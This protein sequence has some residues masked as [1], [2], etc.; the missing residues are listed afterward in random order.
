[1]AKFVP[2]DLDRELGAEFDGREW[3]SAGPAADLLH[4]LDQ[5]LPEPYRGY[6]A[7]GVAGLLWV[8]LAEPRGLRRCRGHYT[9]L[10]VWRWLLRMQARNHFREAPRTARWT[11]VFHDTLRNLHPDR[12]FS[13]AE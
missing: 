1:M 10:P 2:L 9:K 5:R 3:A 7:E 11:N 13:H 8:R 4:R 12:W 6:T